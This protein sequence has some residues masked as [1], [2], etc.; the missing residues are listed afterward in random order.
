MNLK[1][2]LSSINFGIF[3][4]LSNLE[5]KVRTQK[6]VD[7]NLFFM[8]GK[9]IKMIINLITNLITNNERIT[10]QRNLDSLKINT[11]N[12]QDFNVIHFSLTFLFLRLNVY[13]FKVTLI[14]L[15]CFF[16]YTLQVNSV[17]A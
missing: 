10:T 8:A 2:S 1:I 6:P 4:K 17:I 15:L 7:L 5:L 9:F 11:W 16:F 3:F 12:S 14:I 13:N